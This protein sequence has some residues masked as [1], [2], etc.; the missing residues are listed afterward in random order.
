MHDVYVLVTSSCQMH[1]Y[2]HTYTNMYLSV[3]LL[4]VNGTAQGLLHY[5][6][7][8]VWM[9]KLLQMHREIQQLICCLLEKHNGSL[10]ALSL[11]AA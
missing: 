7:I 3:S 11:K 10:W 1:T 8:V 9:T 4:S 2:M 5:I 6:I